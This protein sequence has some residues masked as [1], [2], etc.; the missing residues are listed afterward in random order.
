M[1][2]SLERQTALLYSLDA[3]ERIADRA[4][5]VTKGRNRKMNAVGQSRAVNED[6]RSFRSFLQKFGLFLNQLPA[7][8]FVAKGRGQIADPFTC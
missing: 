5:M 2:Y 7:G 8:P 3:P 4:I 6:V 1:L